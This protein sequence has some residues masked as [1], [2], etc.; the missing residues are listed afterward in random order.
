MAGWTSLSNSIWCA[1]SCRSREATAGG[2]LFEADA[3]NEF[4]KVFGA[5]EQLNFDAQVV[6]GNVT[7]F[8]PG[9][10]DGVFFGGDDGVGAPVAAVVDEVQNFL[11]G[12]AVVV[13]VAFLC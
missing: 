8:H 3:G 11:L 10:A 9:Q 1:V 12:V 7:A 6:H 5:A 13:G 2:G 4:L